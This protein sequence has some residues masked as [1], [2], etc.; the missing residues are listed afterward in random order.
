MCSD[1]EGQERLC[2]GPG[3]ASSVVS[4]EMLLRL[5]RFSGKVNWPMWLQC[6][7]KFQLNSP[8]PAPAALFQPQ[9]PTQLAPTVSRRIVSVEKNQKFLIFFVCHNAAMTQ[10]IFIFSAEPVPSVQTCRA[11]LQPYD[12]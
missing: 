10:S 11:D 1:S 4:A 8:Q 5:R 9:V 2:H 12:V 3:Y 6:I 7:C